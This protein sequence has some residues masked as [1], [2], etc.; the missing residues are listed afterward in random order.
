MLGVHAMAAEPAVRLYADA[1]AT[2]PG[3]DA[4]ATLLARGSALRGAGLPAFGQ[5]VVVTDGSTLVGWATGLSRN[6]RLR[7]PAGSG[8]YELT[9]D[10]SGF[11]AGLDRR[12]GDDAVAGLA[13][14]HVETAWRDGPTK[15][16][17][18]LT[19]LGAYGAT[20]WGNL[21]YVAL[22]AQYTFDDT[23]ARLRDRTTRFSPGTV[24]AGGTVGHFIDLSGFTFNPLIE[25]EYASTAG[26]SLRQSDAGAATPRAGGQD[27]LALRAGL[28]VNSA[29]Y[30]WGILAAPHVA[31]LWERRLIDPETAGL[32][33]HG[34]GGLVTGGLVVSLPHGLYAGFD[35][36]TRFGGKLD[37]RTALLSVAHGF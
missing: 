15:A 3:T 4:F 16:A 35:V 24:R 6:A 29:A 31:V 34:D 25:L 26:A 33:P 21:L 14:S 12:L 32:S 36:G 2:D 19:T 20:A 5:A 1:V 22:A 8:A 10:S 13:V 28:R 11:V 7:P 18:S 9:D 27:T 17:S 30:R 23:T 37:E